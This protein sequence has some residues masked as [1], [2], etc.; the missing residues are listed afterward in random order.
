ME[1]EPT[2]DE[3]DA[4]YPES[5]P[6]VLNGLMSEDFDPAEPSLGS[7]E[8]AEWMDQER[9]ASSSTRDLEDEHDGAEPSEDGEPSLGAFEGHDNLRV[10]WWVTSVMD[11]ELDAAES[12]IGDYDGLAEQVGSQDWQQGALARWT[13]T[14]L[15]CV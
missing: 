8:R 1:L 3:L 6:R 15:E 12:G 14:S 10:A 9:W 5:G 4:S 2:G 7:I 11:Y 13:G